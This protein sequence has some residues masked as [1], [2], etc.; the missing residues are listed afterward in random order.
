M[1]F[2]IDGDVTK[3]HSVFGSIIPHRFGLRTGFLH[4]QAIIFMII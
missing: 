3:R 1:G 2:C 4:D